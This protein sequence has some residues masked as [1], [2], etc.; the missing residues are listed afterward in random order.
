[1]LL[2]NKIVQEYRQKREIYLKFANTVH[3]LLENILGETTIPIHSI[4]S[5][6]KEVESLSEKIRRPDKNYQQLKEITDLVGIRITTYFED[7]IDQVAEIVE[8]SFIIDHK[9]STDKRKDF[10][11]SQFGYN[12]LH[13]IARIKQTQVEATKYFKFKDLYF[14][15][16]IRSILQH[17]WAEVEHDLGYKHRKEI[18]GELKRRFARLSALMEVADEEF[19]NLRNRI[20]AY[21]LELAAKMKK[22]P[23]KV[24]IDKIS[25]R[26]FIEQNETMDELIDYFSNWFGKREMS[27]GIEDYYIGD[28]VRGLPYIG[29]LNIADLKTDLRKN[30]ALIKE[31]INYVFSDEKKGSGWHPSMIIFVLILARIAIENKEKEAN[32]IYQQLK[33]EIGSDFIEKFY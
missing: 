30:V 21:E 1:M 7:D 14:E 10:D 32:K 31:S 22:E 23:E 17:A 9:N 12:S 26:K 18:P 27:T 5:R 4:N 6:T 8:D 28:V 20:N 13:K 16:Q 24:P 25:I 19:I 2:D 11:Y 15:I 33:I 29:I 3:D